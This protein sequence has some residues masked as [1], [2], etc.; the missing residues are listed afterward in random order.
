[1]GSNPTGRA[2]H[3][4]GNDMEKKIIYFEKGGPEN[5]SI[6]LEE[7]EMRAKELGINDVVVATTHGGTALK[8][9][10]AFPEGT[11]IVAVSIHE[12]YSDRE[13]W[14]MT[15]EERAILHSEGIKVIT[16]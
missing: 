10:E 16:L 14:C 13:G 3:Y 1:M 7:A 15:D 2:K 6:L 8:T 9:K 5:T 12:G 11:N 4:L